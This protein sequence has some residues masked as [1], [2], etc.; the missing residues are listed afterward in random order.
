M[1]TH[2]YKTHNIIVEV[3]TKIWE[4]YMQGSISEASRKGHPSRKDIK[5]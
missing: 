2:V 4:Y 3:T 1:E 5:P